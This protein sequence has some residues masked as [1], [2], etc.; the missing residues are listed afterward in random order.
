M[1]SIRDSFFETSDRDLLVLDL[2]ESDAVVKVADLDHVPAELRAAP[3]WMLWKYE[4]KDGNSKPT[5]V[6]Y[7]VRNPELRASSTEPA[8]WASFEDATEALPWTP[9]DGLGFALGDGFAGVDL[10]GC[11]VDGEPTAFGR[12]ILSELPPTYTETSPSGHGLHAVYRG[13]IEKG[14][15]QA[16]LEIYGAGRFFTI[17]GRQEPDSPGTLAEATDQLLGL[18]GRRRA[19]T[20]GHQDGGIAAVELPAVIPAGERH[21]ALVKWVGRWRELGF[22]RAEAGVL[23]RELVR[24]CEQPTGDRFGEREAE[25]LFAD[26]WGRYA[27]G[28]PPS[29]RHAAGPST[30][31]EFISIRTLAERVKAA[32]PRRFLIR[33][34]WPGGDY[35]VHAA[36]PKAHKT[37]NTVDAVVSVASGTPLFG[38]VPVDMSGRVLMLCGEGGEGNVFRRIGATAAARGLAAEDLPIDVCTRAPHLGD[39]RHLELLN[40]QIQKTRPVLVTLDPLYLAAKGANL[41]DLYKMGEFLERPQHMC[42]EVGAALWVV[43]HY[44]RKEGRGASRILGAG[45]AEWGRVLLPAELLTRHKDPLTGATDTLVEISV[46]G[47]EVAD[48]T[49]RVRRI[50]RPERPGD[51]DSPLH[52]TVTV[53]EAD[54]PASATYSPAATKLLEALGEL[55]TATG[56][57][58]VDSIASRHGH[59]LRRETVSRT[60]ND[61]LKRGVVEVDGD[62]DGKF[63]EKKWRLV[64]GV[65]SVV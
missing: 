27:A 33:E 17:T 34:L 55:G 16:G 7:Q 57:A 52:V 22:S 24:R 47:G 40:D 26:L 1:E 54:Q 56:S 60:L 5:K 38:H 49:L 18:I 35:G 31:L 46:L 36:E 37:W 58:L 64:E 15:K 12:G 51:L 53:E 20:N 28:Q 9:H 4:H 23:Y 3:R 14:L 10:D 44:N 6:P 41:A 59:G 25:A 65:P 42:A 48:R 2:S 39:E 19:S 62:T 21:N 13:N 8:T 32:G 30:T 63:Q 61:L 11:I 29:E 50:V 45:P 43:T